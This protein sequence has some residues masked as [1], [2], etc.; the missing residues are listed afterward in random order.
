[1][2]KLGFDRKWVDLILNCITFI[3]YSIIVNGMRG[4]EFYPSRGLRQGDPLSPFL[5]L[6]C[7]KGL[8]TLMRGA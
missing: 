6:L 5:F 2:L 4:N 1:M 3:S 7:S 8:S